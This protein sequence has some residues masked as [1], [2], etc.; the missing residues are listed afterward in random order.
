[1]SAEDPIR[2]RTWPCDGPDCR[3]FCQGLG[4]ATP[5]LAVLG[6]HTADGRLL[7]PE[8]RTDLQGADL[9]SHVQKV[10]GAIRLSSVVGKL[11]GG[12]LPGVGDGG[13]YTGPDLRLP[14]GHPP[15]PPNEGG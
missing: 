10:Q 3:N 6:W 12:A 1:M 4:E 9:R 8:C 2:C 15:T 13:G 7:C 11:V 14:W 5:A